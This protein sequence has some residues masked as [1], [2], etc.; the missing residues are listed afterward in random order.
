M[1]IFLGK[2]IFTKKKWKWKKGR[3]IC[4]CRIK[5]KSRK[6]LFIACSRLEDIQSETRSWE[7]VG[8]EKLLLAWT[9]LQDSPKG[10][11]AKKTR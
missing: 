5:A 10:I 11:E 6:S 7:A 2:Q 1:E 9:K 4:A 8:V 3:N